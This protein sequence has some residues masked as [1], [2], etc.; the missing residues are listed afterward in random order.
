MSKTERLYVRVTPKEKEKILHNA[1]VCGLSQSEYLRQLAVGYQPMPILPHDFYVFHNE[2][3]KLRRKLKDLNYETATAQVD[4]LIDRINAK[5]IY[6][7]KSKLSEIKEEVD[8]WQQS[9]SGL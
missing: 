3:Y 7:T 4:E 6:P 1:K 2:L 5:F 8:K 9:D